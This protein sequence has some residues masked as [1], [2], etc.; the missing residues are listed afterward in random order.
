MIRI[1]QITLPF[2]HEPAALK[3]AL[4]EK[5]NLPERELLGFQIV[6]KSIDARKKKRIL[7]VYSVDVQVKDES[8]FISSHTGEPNISPSPDLRY[9][10]P[11]T[12]RLNGPPPVVVGTGPCGLFAGLILAQAG[13]CPILVERGK[14]VQSRVQD[15]QRF[16]KKG[17]FKPESNVPFGEGGAGTFSDGKLTTQIRDGKNRIGKVLLELVKAGA[18][19]EILY[20]AKPHLG[21]DNLIK[22]VRNLRK[23]ILSLGGQ[24]RFDT[25]LTGIR[26]K[27]NSVYE[28]IFNDSETVHT[29]TLIL[30]LGHSARGTFQM[31]HEQNIPMMAKAFSIGVRIEHPQGLI[32][33]AQH[34]PFASHPRLGPADYRLVHHCPNGRA[35]YTF[36]MCPGGRVIGASSE[37]G[38]IVVNGMSLYARNGPNANSALLVGVNPDD[39]DSNSPLS[40]VS[41]QRQWERKAFEMGGGNYFAPVQRVEDFLSGRASIAMGQ[42]NPSYLPGTTPG[43]LTRCLPNFVVEALQ[44]AIPALNRKL[45]GFAMADAV[46]TAVETGSSSPVRILRDKT[47]QSPVVSGIYPAGEGAGYAG[48]IISSAVDGIR[49]AEAIITKTR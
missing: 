23:T 25:Q 44:L 30:A 16:W 36:C 21:T 43:D 35:A 28:A 17:L 34:G 39:F 31:L 20:E 32:D 46:M 8:R 29:D 37:P 10:P 47:Y 2:D 38:G 7:A 40:G 49:V 18:P 45:K 15:V 19:E 24:V 11:V 42:V 27:E 22:I 3:R 6:R 1:Q 4:L 14:A 12:A 26:I 13:L 33:Q 5:L 41:F 48:G 9:R